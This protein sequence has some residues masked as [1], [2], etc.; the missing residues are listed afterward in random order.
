MSYTCDCCGAC[1]KTFPIYAST[2]D[3]AREPLIQ[4][5]GLELK[6][7]LG[8]S[9]WRYRLFPLPFQCSCTFLGADKLCKIYERRP[10]VC[11]R[12]EAGSAQCQEA[13]ARQGLRELCPD[14]AS[15]SSAADLP[16]SVR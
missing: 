8:D 13:R 7:W 9:E 10:G 11:R 15:G 2:E 1:C 14:A 4:E 6:E 5:Q 3:A 16:S 12:F